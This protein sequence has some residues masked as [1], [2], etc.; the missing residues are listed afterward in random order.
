M[1]TPVKVQDILVTLKN[2]FNYLKTNPDRCLSMPANR[3]ASRRSRAGEKRKAKNKF[4]TLS[5][6]TVYATLTFSQSLKNEIKAF[7]RKIWAC[8]VE[9]SST[10][11]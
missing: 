6:V 11:F 2:Y 7:E 9:R 5:Y 4:H 3:G 8:R 1:F 10:W